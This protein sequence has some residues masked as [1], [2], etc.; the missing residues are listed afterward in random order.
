[1]VVS[2]RPTA[3]SVVAEEVAGAFYRTRIVRSARAAG[4]GYFAAPAAA[5]LAA[6]SS[7]FFAYLPVSKANARW[8]RF[9]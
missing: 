8:L 2:S 9:S 4:A 5:Q 3:R 6:F 1:M 7:V